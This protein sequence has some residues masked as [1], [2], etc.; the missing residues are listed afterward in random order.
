MRVFLLSA[1]LGSGMVA[2]LGQGM[3]GEAPRFP[4]SAHNL[5]VEA[6][7]SGNLE[8]YK[9]G[10]RG[11]P[12]HM[13]YDLQRRRFLKRSQWHEYGVGFGQ[14]L[15]VVPEEEPAFWT[16]EWKKPIKANLIVLS[17]VYPNQPQPETCWKIELRRQ[18]KWTTH[19]RGK[20]G[21]YDRKRYVWGGAG[22]KPTTFDAIRVSVF[23]K[24]AK[25]PIRSIHFRGEEGVSWV[26]ADLPPI[27][28][29]IVA[30][31]TPVRAG[32][33]VA[34][35]AEALAG[36][37]KTWRWDFGEGKMAKGHKASHAFAKPGAHEVKL[38]FS[39]GEHTA[40][41][42]TSVHVK[43][44]VEGRITP[45]TASVM[46]GKPAE[47]AGE[48]SIGKVRSFKWDFGDG[49]SAKGSKARYTFA[50]AGIYKVRLTV[51]DGQ[52]RDDCLA[53]IRAHTP[54]TLHVPQVFLDTDQKNEVDDQHY[55]GYAL[56]SELDVLGVN[57]IHHGGGQ[58]PINYRELVNVL[59]LAKRSGLPEHR[60]T[61]IYRGA[62]Q[63]LDV[64]ASGKWD[65]TEPII[66]EASEGILAAARGAS[67]SNP[68]W[69]VPVG[70]GT[71]VASAILQAR[72]EGLELKGRMRVMWLG[73]SNHAI[74]GEFNGN[75]DP[76]SMYVVSQ[77]GLETWIM[78]APVGGRIRMDVRKESD[79]YAD[80]PLG[81]YLRAIVPKRN[82]SLY[83]PSCLSAIIS[84]RL[85]LG[86]V[87]QVE[88]VTVAGPK[89]GYRWKK[90]E[91]PA[92]VRVIR[93]IDQEAMKRD[94]FETMK[95][96]ARR[97]VG[98]PLKN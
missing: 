60:V 34:F 64:P 78:P 59:G 82:K 69:V 43:P 7:V 65:D 12:D 71:N 79:L 25:S 44:P 30:P 51:S 55:F 39:D 52:Y 46:V 15:G 10:R 73:G 63:R 27:D 97:L 2:C 98:I 17:G 23:S 40:M 36:D 70:P 32:E 57:S 38:T 9:K 13:I 19:A 66:T 77:G 28:A 74:R 49:G 91:G 56:F 96:K 86:W 90:P 3:S 24:D 67:P 58:E 85:G 16:A 14:D 88:P 75:N 61:T 8:T 54:E 31:R 89:G 83:D 33:P 37:I 29:R 93:Q 4:A 42:R 41:V 18:G 81:R 22:T 6:K 80:H 21:W 5:L 45:L 1:A 76:W 48:G 26:V 20:G 53:I 62:N 94:I 47:F 95:G 92:T 84:M 87:K 50:R 72:A 68:L 35:A 11:A